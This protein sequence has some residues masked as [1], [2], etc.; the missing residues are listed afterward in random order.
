M[1]TTLLSLALLALLATACAG[2]A[3]PTNGPFQSSP[4]GHHLPTPH[5]A[6]PAGPASTPYPGVTYRDPGENP[7]VDPNRDE[8]STFGLDVD[9]RE[10]AVVAEREARGVPATDEVHDFLDL[11]DDLGRLRN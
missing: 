2:T 4:V 7:W 5:P 10:V 3:G 1:R 9:I 8:H 6:Q 11:L